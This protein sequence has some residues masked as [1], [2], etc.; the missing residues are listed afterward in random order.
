MPRETSKSDIIEFIHKYYKEHNTTPKLKE[1][2]VKDGFPCN[3]ERLLK[4]CGRYNDLIEFIGYETYSYGQRHYNKNKLLEDLF[5]AVKQHRSVDFRYIRENNELKHRDIYKRQFGSVR[6][7]LKLIGISNNN[8]LLMKDFKSYEFTN[9]LGF[10]KDYVY[11]GIISKDQEEL[12][13]IGKNLLQ[14]DL[15]A[16]INDIGKYIDAYKIYKHFIKFEYFV[17]MCGYEC[18]STG[19][20]L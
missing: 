17:I 8:I 16:N 14:S 1:W 12:I 20:R 6:K 15:T 11:K 3:K 2:K 13:S 7:A 4:I 5:K 18:R 9:P 19:R 10:L